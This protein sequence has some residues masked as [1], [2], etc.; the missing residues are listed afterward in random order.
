MTRPILAAASSRPTDAPFLSTRRLVSAARLR[1]WICRPL[2]H[3]TPGLQRAVPYGPDL[4][5]WLIFELACVNFKSLID[6]ASSVQHS[7]LGRMGVRA[8]GSRVWFFLA[9]P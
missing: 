7:P 5:I 4:C 2:S 3:D 1:L 6:R 9:K 8:E